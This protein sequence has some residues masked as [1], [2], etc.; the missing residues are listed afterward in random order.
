[1]ATETTKQNSGGIGFIGLLQILFLYLKFTN[2][3]HWSWWLVLLP[4]VV[5]AVIISLGLGIILLDA[6]V[7]RATS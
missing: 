6:V 2:V 3:I 7:N 1:M 5:P 4:S